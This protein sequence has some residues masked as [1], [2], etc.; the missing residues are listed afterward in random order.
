M[1]Q[2]FVSVFMYKT[3]ATFNTNCLKLPLSVVVSINNYRKTFL[4]AYCYITLESAA[5][6]KFVTNQLSDLAFNNCP[7]A[8]VIV[9]DFSKGLRAA[10]VA[11]AAVDLSLTE[12]INKALVCPLERDKELLEA[13]EVIVHK[14]FRALQQLLL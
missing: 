9:R 3:D 11:K 7:I 5:S 10:C 12:I 14:A 2:Q 4:I 1:T 6:F 13:A 8:A